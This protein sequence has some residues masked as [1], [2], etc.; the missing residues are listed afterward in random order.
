MASP[1][2]VTSGGISV[3]DLGKKN[4]I[5][6][7]PGTGKTTTLS[8]LINGYIAEGNRPSGIA[9]LTYSRSMANQAKQ[10]FGLDPKSGAMV[11]TFHSIGSRFLG[12][13]ASRRGDDENSDFL[14]ERMI[15]EFC[16]KFGIQ[17]LASS[18]FQTDYDDPEGTDEFSQIMAASDLTRNKRDGSKPSDYLDSKRFDADYIV[19]QLEKLKEQSGKHDYTDIL[20]ASLD[21]D[22]SP[23]DFLII[24]EAQD[25][26]PLMWAIVKRIRQ[27]AS[28][29]VLAGDDMQSIY[30]FR[31]ASPVDFLL[32]RKDAKVFHLSKSYRLPSEVKNFSDQI[33]SRVAITEDVKFES[34]G[35]KGAVYQWSLEDFLA[36]RGEKWILCRTGFVVKK[37]KEFLTMYN[38]LFYPLNGRHRG[39]SPWTREDFSLINALH[40]WP[41]LNARQLEEV[42]KLLP[43]NVLIRG[44]KTRVKNGEAS[45]LMEE[46]SRGLYG[47]FDASHLFK[48]VP[49]LDDVLRSLD[50]GAIKKD[51]IAPHI[52]HG[53]KEED[54]VRLDTIHAAKGLEGKHVAIVTDLTSKVAR[55]M[56]DNPSEE[57]R[58]FY[59]GVT[60]ASETISLISL[61]VGRGAYAV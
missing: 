44:V 50:L 3:G 32:Q 60:R 1:V 39:F 30:S 42:I 58:I 53:L 49:S 22:F 29:V 24:D 34:N 6:G 5:I 14:T 2:S 48:K 4:I 11:G 18:S 37:V 17:K 45:K 40:A 47:S 33:S 56:A 36:L 13:H 61:G 26:T 52:E 15:E 27:Y 16:D 41:N 20:V 25:L 31:G 51:L 9:Y 57:Y 46:Y 54:I 35:R 55:N 59:T 10:R 8:N 19:A 12:W 38:L 7:R 43:A 28:K 21:V 23:I